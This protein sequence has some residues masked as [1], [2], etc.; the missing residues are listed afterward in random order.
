MSD[1][2]QVL[3][4]AEDLETLI[5][6]ATSLSAA[7]VSLASS[8]SAQ[9]ADTE[10]GSFV[11]ISEELEPEGLENRRFVWESQ[12]NRIAEDGPPEVPEQLL[13][14]GRYCLPVSTFTAHNRVC[15]AFRAGFWARVAL[16]CVIPYK[17]IEQ[18]PRVPA[19]WIVLR[20]GGHKPAARFEN[21]TSFEHYV[22]GASDNVLIYEA[23]QNIA[24][25]HIFCHA[26]RI[27]LP[28]CLVWRS[29][30]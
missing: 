7:A 10:I 15:E 25:V 6:A 27:F 24:E 1:Q 30:H 14:F 26:A 20:V 11:R 22:R 13:E 2:R 23:F 9:R 18:T 19:H 12:F 4:N 17:R 29:N 8:A 3:V 16:D 28:Q 21:Q 5:Q